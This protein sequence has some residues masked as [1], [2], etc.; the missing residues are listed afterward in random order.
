MTSY[1]LSILSNS[2]SDSFKKQ[3]TK[4]KKKKNDFANFWV[5]FGQSLRQFLAPESPLKKMKNAFYFTLKVLFVLKIFKF[6]S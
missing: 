2:V 4:E 6:L 1:Y 3:R 5:G